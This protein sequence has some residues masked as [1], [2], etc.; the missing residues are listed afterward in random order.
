LLRD[1]DRIDGLVV[2]LDACHSGHAAVEVA[3]GAAAVA[4]AAGSR[5]DL[6]T[7]T[8]DREA[9]RGCFTQSL[10]GL[11]RAGHAE[12][13]ERLGCQD[14]SATDQAVRRQVAITGG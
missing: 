2:L 5:F 14:A 11:L 8:D 3:G 1:Y 7:A 4:M 13:G 6:V 10:T 9:A 12:R